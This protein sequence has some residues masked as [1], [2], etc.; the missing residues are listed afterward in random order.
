MAKEI[1]RTFVTVLDLDIDV[2][3]IH[4]FI[5]IGYLSELFKILQLIDLNDEVDQWNAVVCSDRTNTE[6]MW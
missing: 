5:V 2:S 4:S 1:A 6:N 3:S